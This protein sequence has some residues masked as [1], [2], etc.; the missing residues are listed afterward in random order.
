M[1]I[2]R[3]MFLPGEIFQKF[4]KCMLIGELILMALKILDTYRLCVDDNEHTGIP[5][6][7][8]LHLLCPGR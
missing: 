5:I 3:M 1:Y 4:G 8:K 2:H 7:H 6:S